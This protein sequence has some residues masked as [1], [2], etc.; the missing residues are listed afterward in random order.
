MDPFNFAD[1]LQAIL[2]QRLTKALC[3]KCKQAYAPTADEMDELVLEYVEGTPLDPKTTLK[4]WQADYGKKKDFTLYRAA[5]CRQCNHTGYRGR[6]GLH[7]LMTVTPELKRMIQLRAPVSELQP[8]AI[9]AGM[10]TLKQ[11]GISKVLQGQT[12]MAQVRA[13]CM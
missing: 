6:M 12:D 9:N 8:A 13:V 10:R 4:E 3:P 1:A 5:G 7:E 2:A 11:D